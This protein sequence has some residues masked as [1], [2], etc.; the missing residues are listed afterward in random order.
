MTRP[1]VVLVTLAAAILGAP[2]LL[3]QDVTKETWEAWGKPLAERLRAFVPAPPPGLA[4]SLP[5]E[6]PR[7]VDIGPMSCLEGG[8]ASYFWVQVDKT[9]FRYDAAM[10]AEVVETKRRYDALFARISRQTSQ[11]ELQQITREA[12]P[13]HQRMNE[14]KRKLGGIGFTIAANETPELLGVRPAGT[15]KGY[16]FYRGDQRFAVYVGP[17]GFTNPLLRPPAYRRE[18]KCIL[19]HALVPSEQSPAGEIIVS[20]AEERLARQLLERVDYAGLAKLLTP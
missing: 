18:V 2:P 15:I 1:V 7:P 12:E 10:V 14:L 6:S 13:L 20:P 4:D 5:W 17:A 3:A 11:S 8:C 19:V 9:W 16:P